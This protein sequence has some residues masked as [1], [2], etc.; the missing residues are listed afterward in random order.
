MQPAMSPSKTITDP[1]T[2]WSL[3]S[4]RLLCGC[5]SFRDPPPE[6]G[7]IHPEHSLGRATALHSQLLGSFQRFSHCRP[8]GTPRLTTHS[9]VT[10][11]VVILEWSQPPRASRKRDVVGRSQSRP[12]VASAVTIAVLSGTRRGGSSVPVIG[13]SSAP[14]L[15]PSRWRVVPALH[16]AEPLTA[17]VASLLFFVTTAVGHGDVPDC[18]S[19]QSLS[20]IFRPRR[21]CTMGL[22][23]GAA[24][25]ALLYSSFA[26]AGKNARKSKEKKHSTRPT[27][28]GER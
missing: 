14:A 18:H 21:G 4:T 23:D 24:D 13:S 5:R 25:T 15:S 17:P 16:A 11:R 2:P 1:G 28:H 19:G 26:V 7:S 22:H 20:Q 6:G 9:H 27:V 8:A 3:A 12:R 10:E